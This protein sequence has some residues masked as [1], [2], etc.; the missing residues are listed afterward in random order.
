[1]YA[2]EKNTHFIEKLIM[3]SR[4][5]GNGMYFR[6]AYKPFNVEHF[7]FFVTLRHLTGRRRYSYHTYFNNWKQFLNL[8]DN[9]HIRIYMYANNLIRIRRHIVLIKCYIY[10]CIMY[11]ISNLFIIDF[12]VEYIIC[13]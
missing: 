4:S 11:A 5:Y 9:L 10:V 2:H 1:M 7:W 13:F 12:N 3:A 6:N 8:F